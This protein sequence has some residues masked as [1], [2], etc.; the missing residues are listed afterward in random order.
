MKEFS[1]FFNLGKFF[2]IEGKVM[3]SG[4]F[5]NGEIYNGSGKFS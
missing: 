1:H 5:K 4:E 3:L 2:Q